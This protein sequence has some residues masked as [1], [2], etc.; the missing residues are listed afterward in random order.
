MEVSGQLHA[1]VPLTPEKE[2]PL[3][4]NRE[5]GYLIYRKL[6]SNSKPKSVMIANNM[7]FK[8]TSGLLVKRFRLCQTNRSTEHSES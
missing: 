2:Y 8:F 4:R 6:P 5:R 1:P 3:D 7:N